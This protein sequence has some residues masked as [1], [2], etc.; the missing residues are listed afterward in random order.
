[1]QGRITS[2]VSCLSCSVFFFFFAFFLPSIDCW[3]ALFVVCFALVSFSSE[4][5]SSST[6]KTANLEACTLIAIIVYFRNAQVSGFN[7][8]CSEYARGKHRLVLEPSNA[9]L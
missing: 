8:R 2:S 5:S 1:M 9:S 6:C 4:S 3:L 7:G